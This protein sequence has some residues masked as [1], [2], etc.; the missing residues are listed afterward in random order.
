MRL[1]KP[2]HSISVPPSTETFYHILVRETIDCVSQENA[3][4]QAV[5]LEDTARLP[6]LTRRIQRNHLFNLIC[7]PKA[8]TTQVQL[9]MKSRNFFSILAMLHSLQDLKLQTRD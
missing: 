9:I 4:M 7:G 8:L 3:K 1:H 6:A 2:D 5:S